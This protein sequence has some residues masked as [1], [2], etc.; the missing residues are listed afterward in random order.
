MK[1]IFSLLLAVALVIPLHGQQYSSSVTPL[2]LPDSAATRTAGIS[3]IAQKIAEDNKI[4]LVRRKI[5]SKE[6]VALAIGMMV[7]IGLILGS[8]QSWNPSGRIP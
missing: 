8:T 2:T 4:R 1:K 5:N 7:F 3:S 6:F